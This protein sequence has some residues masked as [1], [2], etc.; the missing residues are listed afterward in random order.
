MQICRLQGR[1]I[2]GYGV[3]HKKIRAGPNKAGQELGDLEASQG[4]FDDHGDFESKGLKG[5]VGIL[6]SKTR[7]LQVSTSEQI[8]VLRHKNRGFVPSMH[9]C[10]N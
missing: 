7:G 5:K 2:E 10:Q 1:E 9:E 3:F 8:G 6:E 4:T